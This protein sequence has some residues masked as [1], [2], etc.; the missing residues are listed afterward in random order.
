MSGPG[1]ILEPP[2][3]RWH[4]PNCGQRDETREWQAHVRYHTCPKLRYLSAPMVPQGE[5]AK[6]ELHEPDDYI[7]SELVTRDP[8]LGRP[9][10]NIITTRGEGRTDCMVFAPA[11]RIRMGVPE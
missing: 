10:M 8:E 9:V 2:V 4:C 3:R 7:G 1:R 6:V 11:V 5:Q